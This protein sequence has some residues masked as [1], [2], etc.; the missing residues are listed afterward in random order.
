M[1]TSADPCT[2]F[3]QYVCGSWGTHNPIPDDS[4]EWSEDYIVIAKTFERIR[5][6]LEE[7]DKPTDILPVKLARKFY[8]SCMNE[9]AIEKR[10]I[11]SIQEILDTTGGW[12]MAMPA[13]IWESNRISWQK[14]DK[15]YVKIFGFSS[16][17][18]IHYDVDL[19][20]TKKYIIVIDQDIDYLL[21][22]RK[23]KHA[24][25]YEL[26]VYA[27][28]IFRIVKAFAK[29]KG[30]YLDEHQLFSD[31]T[32]MEAFENELLQILQSGKDRSS[33][34]DNYK[35]MTIE[36]L[37]KWYNESGVVA[38]TAKINFLDVIQHAF[39][40]ANISVNASDPI[41]VYN[42]EFLHDLARLLGKTSRR[43]LVNYIQW[44]IVRNVLEYIIIETRNIMSN[45]S[46]PPYNVSHNVPRWRFCVFNMEMEDAVS[47]MFV[48]KYITDDVINETKQMADRIQGVLR[49]FLMQTRWI[50]KAV[51]ESLVKKLDNVLTQ[52]GYP[53]WY[54]DDKAMIQRYE[55]LEIGS[56]YVK[57]I[58]NCLKQDIIW[59]LK[60]ITSPV[61]RTQWIDYPITVNAFNDQSVNVILIPAAELQ[62]PYLTPLLP[63]A[64]NYG[65]TGFTIGHELSHSFDNDGILYDM[66]G[67]KSEWIPQEVL[68][69]YENRTTC[70][71]NQYNDYTLDVLDEYGKHIQLDGNLTKTENLADSVGVQ[72]AFAA[73]Q[74]L[75]KEKPQMKL[76]GL[77]NVTN[78]ELFFLA[79]AN[80]WCSSIKPEYEADVVNVEGHSPAKY[81]VIGSLSNMAA[82]SQTFKCP[83]NS[84]MN[85]QDKCTLWN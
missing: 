66:E 73:Y 64:V 24:N 62:D 32:K 68:D 14:I 1:D 38:S 74:K 3:Y 53:D 42:P 55:G 83:Q 40:L 28:G 60:V 7:H 35:R 51:K 70:Y 4:S 26:D 34:N 41:V 54:N 69:E 29:E 80:S 39:R 16:F 75:A 82:F 58:M 37:Q 79:F 13:K 63:D 44:N 81:R 72:V 33:Y 15:H 21:S 11:K 25:T 48:K 2:D 59:S 5:D 67:Y 49:R 52:I 85:P 46:F 84:S 45:M 22:S 43:V 20:N 23:S 12:P 50:S 78:D 8:R 65:T 18:G 6:V 77:E 10:G 71:I 61:D 9:D 17:F 57:N 31:M 19:N 47:Y 36:E 27:L 30:Y 56:D 76:P